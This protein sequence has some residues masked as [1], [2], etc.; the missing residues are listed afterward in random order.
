MEE[1]TATNASDYDISEI[2]ARCLS[3]KEIFSEDFVLQEI[4]ACARETLEQY[5]GAPADK[6]FATRL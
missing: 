1:P 6:K 5:A 3:K 4:D 2:R